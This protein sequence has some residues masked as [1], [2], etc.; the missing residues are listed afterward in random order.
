MGLTD[1]DAAYWG[2]NV[3]VGCSC[4]GVMAWTP[5]R[6]F[7]GP[8]TVFNV[9]LRL[10]SRSGGPRPGLQL[11][12]PVNLWSSRWCLATRWPFNS[13]S[14]ASPAAACGKASRRAPL[15]PLGQRPAALLMGARLCRSG[16]LDLGRRC[17]WP[18]A[19]LAACCRS[20][21]QL[22]ARAW[23]DCYGPAWRTAAGVAGSPAAQPTDSGNGFQPFV[24]KPHLPF[25]RARNRISGG[26][27]P[28]HH[29][30]HQE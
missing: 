23:G 16:R 7:D 15:A 17:A 26:C 18:A 20:G 13:D 24:L 2:A 8:E 5:F 27:R 19:C 12:R 3:L 14:P 1:L 11:R 25:L 22:P 30:T 10:G 29:R 9:H 28:K 21:L 4:P 6:V